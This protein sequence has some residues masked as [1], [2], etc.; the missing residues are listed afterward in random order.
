[1]QKSV[2]VITGVSHGNGKAICKL[3]SKEPKA[4]ILGVDLKQCSSDVQKNLSK[5]FLADVSELETSRKILR[6]ATNF[7][8]NVFLIN[9]AGI[10]KP[11]VNEYTIQDFDQTLSVNLRAPFIWLENYRNLVESDCIKSGGVVNILSLAAHLA[12]PHN[13][14]YIAAKHGLLG[15]TKYYALALGK[16]G[17][18]VNSVSPGYVR[19]NMTSNSYRNASRRALISGH[20][21]LN[22]WAET[23]EVASTVRFLLSKDSSFITGADIP[24]D[25]GWLS[26]GMYSEK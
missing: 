23:S 6:I 8:K 15:L 16:K 2:F 9:N 1:M 14:A 3:L 11:N 24:V 25:G 26:R 7:S 18:R 5:F 4:H 19:T 10:T 12:F 13:P 20:A 21:F 22:R 17:I